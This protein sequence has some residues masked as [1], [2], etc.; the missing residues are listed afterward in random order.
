[1]PAK[2]AVLVHNVSRSSSLTPMN[3]ARSAIN[4]LGV[5]VAGCLLLVGALQA[6]SGALAMEFSLFNPCEANNTLSC[7]PRILG[8]GA[9][10][11]GDTKKLRRMFYAWNK[12]ALDGLSGITFHSPGGSLREGILMGREIRKLNL[13]TFAS[14]RLRA[15]DGPGGRES[16]L[17]E[18]MYCMSACAYAF[19]GGVNRHVELGSAIGVHQFASA[20]PNQNSE[21]TA[22][23]TTTLLRSYLGDMGVR[24]ELVDIASVMAPSEMH[25]L[26]ATE[27][28]Q[29][30]L[31]N[32]TRHT[33][34]WSIM[35]MDNGTPLLKQTSEM[36]IHQEVT[37]GLY[38][39]GPYFLLILN[40]IHP[41]DPQLLASFPVGDHPNVEI[42]VDGKFIETA[43]NTAWKRMPGVAG[44]FS[45]TVRLDVA[46]LEAI[47]RGREVSLS[48]NVG[49]RSLA[50]IVPYNV[51]LSS[52]GLAEGVRLLRRTN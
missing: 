16:V 14:A 11:R 13:D 1:M 50:G 31:D 33:S 17:V 21:S 20:K 48:D 36:S 9:I 25:I 15:W 27:V 24:P 43:E 38:R 28:K 37:V 10:E 23:V 42:Y 41:T 32:T 2:G 6:T 22:Q 52:K 18:K 46:A 35:A 5:Q 40:I 47:A 19:A 49:G 45:A 7:Q 34:G 8:S 12:K 44:G 3:R 51:P 39:E 26:S 4:S 30:R 29:L